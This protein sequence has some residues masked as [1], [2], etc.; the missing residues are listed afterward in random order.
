[1]THHNNE[2][3]GTILTITLDDVARA[4]ARATGAGPEEDHWKRWSDLPEKDREHTLS[5]CEA[6]TMSQARVTELI[7]IAHQ[8]E[9]VE[10]LRGHRVE[11]VPAR[12][13][14][15]RTVISGTPRL[16]CVKSE[17]LDDWY[18]PVNP[19]N[20]NITVQAGWEDWVR[21]AQAIQDGKTETHQTETAE[22]QWPRTP[23][24]DMP[25]AKLSYL[26][27]ALATGDQ[28]R[29]LTQRMEDWGNMDPTQAD[30][31]LERVR[32]TISNMI[33]WQD[34]LDEAALL[35]VQ[36]RNGET[37]RRVSRNRSVP[38]LI[39]GGGSRLA[40]MLIDHASNRYEPHSPR[41]HNSNGEG[42]LDDWKSL[43]SEIL[44]LERRARDEEQRA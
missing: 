37:R 25:L 24:H 21:L 10:S 19:K 18:L 28:N 2:D 11:P 39:Y 42:N 35:A 17:S 38:G 40:I 41:N 31:L 43:A 23:G 22:E 34:L 33:D 9:Q 14:E 1:M 30:R 26:E 27:V 20:Q 29:T 13:P 5:K 4:H 8:H 7:R 36:E 44:Q 16:A 32:T 15:H 3:T 12:L 6:H